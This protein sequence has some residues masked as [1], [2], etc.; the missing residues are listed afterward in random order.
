[1]SNPK[2]VAGHRAAAFVVAGTVVGLGTGSTA[3]FAIRAIGEPI[4]SR[5][6]DQIS[7]ARL[8][9]LL[10][11]VTALFD[12]KTRT[13][14]VLLQKTMVVVEGVARSLDPRLDL[15]STAEPVVGEWIRQNL[16]PAAAV[17]DARTAFAAIRRLMP[18][19]P[20]LVERAL[21]HSEAQPSSRVPA[22]RVEPRD[23]GV[24]LAL[25][26]IAAL[27]AIGIALR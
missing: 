10:F 27:L 7:M 2:E 26:M 24:L 1:M 23:G 13:E 8:L 16:G 14:L 25:W 15:W 9:A 19:L 6:A 5:T 22:V 21:A 3:E 12:M 4:H 17:Q 11:E 18:I 20:D